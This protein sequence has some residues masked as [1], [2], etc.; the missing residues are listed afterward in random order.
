MNGT[1]NDEHE[2]ALMRIGR[3]I[4]DGSRVDWNQ[5]ETT[6]PDLHTLLESMRVL[7]GVAQAYRGE[8]GSDAPL[9][10]TWGTLE[11]R[12]R[13]G[14]G[15]FG[16]VYRAYD[17]VL[18]AEVALKLR[19]PGGSGADSR[20]FLIEARKLAQIRH[21]NVLVVHGADEREGRIGLWTDLLRG[22]TLEE[23]LETRGPFSAEEAAQIGI[24]ICR[25]LAAVH[26]AGL[27]HCDVKT[28][29]VMRAERGQYVLM[30]FGSVETPGA[31]GGLGTPI[32]MAPEQIRSEPVGPAADIWGLGVLLYRLVSGKYP[33]EAT[34]Y[35]DLLAKHGSMQTVPLRDARPDVPAG[36]ARVVERALSF[37]PARRYATVGAMEQDLMA[38]IGGANPPADPWPEWVRR[39]ALPLAAAAL[40]AVLTLGLVA[41]HGIE[42]RWPWEEPAPSPPAVPT[43]GRLTATAH[44]YR[45]EKSGPKLLI[46]GSTIHP[47]DNLFLEILGTDSMYA[48]VINQD[49]LGHAYVL[50]PGPS[51]D[52][53]GALAPG[54]THRL[55]GTH[56]GV[57]VNWVVSSAGGRETITVIAARHP[58]E[59]IEQD[60]ASIPRASLDADVAY[61]AVSPR[62]LE[63]LRG[64]GGV[65]QESRPSAVGPSVAGKL[66]GKVQTGTTGEVW[67]WQ[68]DLM[69]PAP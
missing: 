11:I 31:A 5:E 41:I 17:P 2:A 35:P 51:F 42:D 48:Y 56:G 22:Q 28:M 55:P 47:G 26:A 8:G 23:M 27:V 16:E 39:A 18:Q 1:P 4:S 33:I 49:D 34:N 59:E 44:V 67:T 9:P 10:A 69:N 7:E 25:A 15:G 37:D 45:D 53:K 54:I 3:S 57:P 68:I 36:F 65:T 58:R 32:T 63:V 12:D 30:D 66:I 64:I 46:P 6:R 43:A 61:S 38:A 52:L 19:R 29:N 21:P 13:I 14:T 62:T 24:Q 60:I 20:R 40:L 50:Y